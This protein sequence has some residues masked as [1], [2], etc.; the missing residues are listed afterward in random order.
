MSGVI[1]L[2]KPGSGKGSYANIIEDQFGYKHIS[3]GELLRDAVASNSEIGKKAKE[4]MKSGRLVPDDIINIIVDELL[5]KDNFILDGYPRTLPQAEFLDMITNIDLVFYFDVPEEVIFNRLLKRKRK[6]DTRE[7]IESRLREYEALTVPLLDYYEDKLIELDA[8]KTIKEVAED[9]AKEIKKGP[10]RE[11]L[12]S[13]AN[14]IL[15]EE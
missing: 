3:T 12:I 14:K 4:Y 11:N 8:S 15:K 1:F 5:P 7:T 13:F 2:G 9:V 10:F 6:D